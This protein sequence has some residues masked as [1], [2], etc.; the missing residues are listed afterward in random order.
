MKMIEKQLQDFLEEA[1]RK[2]LK[3]TTIALY[4]RYIKEFIE[5]TQV[6][7]KEDITKDLL[8]AYK[9]HLREIHPKENT[10][11]NK[12]VTINKFVK[13]LGLPEEMHLKKYKIQR[14]TTLEDVLT[15]TDY[16]RMLRISQARGKTKMYYLQKTLAGTGIRIS[17]LKYITVEAVKKGSAKVENKSKIRTVAIK[18]KLAKELKQYCKDNNITTG[19]IF[20][21]K[22]GKALDRAYVW[23]EL[24]WIAGQARVKKSKIH[25][26]SYRHLFAKSYIAHYGNN[27]VMQLAD[28]L[29]HNSLETTRIYTQNSISEQR[30][31]LD[32]LNL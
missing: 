11:N 15:Q 25:P 9:E 29:G 28:L 10:I 16:E 12:I 4:E 18:S 7:N 27:S 31:L 14:R 21:G 26:H 30:K 6:Q 17:E 23:R 8:I 32:D 13:I 22:S 19:I 2:E 24:Q 3:S 5:Y 1:K 20:K